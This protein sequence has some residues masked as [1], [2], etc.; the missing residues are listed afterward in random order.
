MTAKEARQLAI[1]NG[2]DLNTLLVETALEHI[3][4]ASL[5]GEFN[6]SF[7][8]DPLFDTDTAKSRRILTDMGYLCEHVSFFDNA[9][10]PFKVSNYLKISWW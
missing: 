4:N 9:L 1:D 5:R 2:G 3:K 6:V 10:N 8:F 7:E